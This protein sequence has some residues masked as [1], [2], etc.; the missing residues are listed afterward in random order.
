MQ[1]ASGPSVPTLMDEVGL[2]PDPNGMQIFVTAETDEV[3]RR[4]RYLRNDPD[5]SLQVPGSMMSPE[6]L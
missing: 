6:K 1:L 4:R 2:A 3:E 5:H